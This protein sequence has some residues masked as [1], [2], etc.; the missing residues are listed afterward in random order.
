MTSTEQTIF[1]SQKSGYVPMRESAE[2]SPEMQAYYKENPLF[3]VALKQ[4]DYA[5][6]VPS[7]EQTKRIETEIDKAMEKVVTTS[8]PAEQ[9]MKEAADKIRGYLK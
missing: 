5:K 8:I 2:K 9:A 7:L 1:F 6:E 3:T 4:L